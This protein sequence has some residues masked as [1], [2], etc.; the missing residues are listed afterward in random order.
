MSDP[1]R[2]T[3][4]QQLL[5]RFVAGRDE[6]NY[7]LTKDRKEALFADVTGDVLEIGPGTG[8]NL[9]FFDKSVR[10]TGVEPSKPMQS[11]LLKTAIDLRFQITI[12]TGMSEDLGAED[13]HFDFVISTGVLCSV[14]GVD[15]VLS[16]IHRVLKPGGKFL[17][18]EHVI[19]TE[20][21]FRSMFQ[22]AAPF[23]LWRYVSDGCD[24]GRDTAAAIRRAGFSDISMDEYEQEGAGA[25]SALTRPHISGCAVK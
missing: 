7:R 22:K 17:F 10:W 11:L 8:S 14:K 5:A 23:T 24:P 15:K 19:D 18:I 25:I 13:N 6:E 20:N 2:P 4:R 9:S 12:I 1:V 3:F 21:R 16:E